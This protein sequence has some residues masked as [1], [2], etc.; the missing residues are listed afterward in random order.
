MIDLLVVLV[1]LFLGQDLHV[2]GMC[3]GRLN[4]RCMVRLLDKKG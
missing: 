4:R 3:V 1:L 2:C